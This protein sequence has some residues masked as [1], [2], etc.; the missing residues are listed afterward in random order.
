MSHLKELLRQRVIEGTDLNRNIE[1]DELL[2][3]IDN[4]IMN[5]SR[6][7]YISMQ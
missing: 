7:I 6:E 2:E 1:D 4:V 3:Q 5:Y